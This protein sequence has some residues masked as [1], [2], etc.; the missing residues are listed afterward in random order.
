MI[1]LRHHVISLAAVF[2]ALAIGMILGSGLFSDTMVTGLRGDKGD[3][4]GEVRTLQDQKT[5]LQDKLTAA[6]QFDAQMSG[7]IVR[8][9]LAGK[10]VVLF[11]TPDAADEDVEATTRLIDRAGGRVS[12][13]IALTEEFVAG[14]SADK[15][16][17]VVNSPIL[18]AG[19][20]LGAATDPGTQAGDLIGIALLADRAPAAVPVDDDARAT[21]LTAL[22]DTGFVAYDPD[23]QLGPADTAVII[24]GGALPADAGNRGLTVARFAAGLAPHGAGTVLAGRDGSATG[25]SAVAVAR[26]EPATAEAVTTVD[27]IG[28]ESGRITAVLA[29]QAMI[30]GVPP[31]R[32]GVG[33]GAVSV[34]VPQ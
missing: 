32:Y 34:T 17:S 4:Q 15:L 5:A 28:A 14:D 11:R 20:Q 16:S 7:R 1:S 25:I 19:A 8:D 22:R 3:L 2:L 23:G 27:D 10:S 30:A 12:G 6:D 21:V 13:T 29:L 18:P 33:A 26:S 31:G 24:T 9:A